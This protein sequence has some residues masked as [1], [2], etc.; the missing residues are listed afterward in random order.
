MNIFILDENIETNVKY[1]MDCHVSKMVLETAQLLCSAFYFCD[2]NNYIPPYKLIRN[3]NHICAR[4]TRESLSNWLYLKELGL[5]IGKEY[6]YRYDKIHVSELVIRS[7]PIPNLEDKGLTPFVNCMKPQYIICDDVIIN[8]RNYYVGDKI[9]LA[10]WT[11]REK[12][13]W[14]KEEDVKV[15]E[16]KY[17]N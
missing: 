13:F 5:K 7:L 17:E 12:P 11:K 8:Y 14:Y 6:E 15:K 2:N 1:Y 16:I 10:K 9:H 4:W 3:K